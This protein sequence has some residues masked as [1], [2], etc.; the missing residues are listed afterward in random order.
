ML[1]LPPL[2]RL[3]HPRF[4]DCNTL[5]SSLF[6]RGEIACEPL[7]LMDPCNRLCFPQSMP[8]CRLISVKSGLSPRFASRATEL[9]PLTL[10]LL[11]EH[12]ELSADGGCMKS[13]FLPLAL[14]AL[15]RWSSLR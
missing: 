1:A 14:A 15:R 6:R 5:D 11:G 2:L 8:R 9:G 4:C 7:S 13:G 3:G 10:Y 12:Y